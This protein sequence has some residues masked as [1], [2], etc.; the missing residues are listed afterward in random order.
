MAEETKKDNVVTFSDMAKASIN[1]KQAELNAI[2]TT[3]KYI[4]IDTHG[5]SLVMGIDNPEHVLNLLCATYN[6]MVL[7][8]LDGTAFNYVEML[9][10]NV[11]KALN[12]TIPSIDEKPAEKEG[13]KNNG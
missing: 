9:R 13:E 12:V 10:L 6:G 5:R 4:V 7:N 11:Q 8:V 2:L 1:P 3:G